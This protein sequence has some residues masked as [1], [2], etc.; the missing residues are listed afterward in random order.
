MWD[1]G[2]APTMVIEHGI[3]DPGHRYTGGI[4]RLA[5]VVNEPVRRWR[6]AGTDLLLAMAAGC[7]SRC[8]AWGCRRWPSAR[9]ALP[10][11]CT[12]TCRRRRMHAMLPAAPRLS[13]PLPLDQPG[14]VADRGDDARHAGAGARR[15]PR[16]RSAVPADA[17]VVSADPRGAGRHRAPVAGRSGRGARARPGRRRHAL[18]ALRITAFPVGLADLLK[19]VALMRIAMVSEHASPLAVLG[20]VDAGG[21]N[22]HVAALS[23][24]LAARGHDGH[25]LHPARR[26]RRRRD[27]CRSRPASTSM[28]VP[29]GPPGAA[30]Q[31]RPAAVHAAVRGDWLADAGADGPP[32]VVH[33][34]F[35]MSGLAA[36][37]RGAGARHPGRAD[38][39][40]ARHR[41]APPPG[42]PR[43]Q[44]RRR[45]ELE[46][47]IGGAS[48]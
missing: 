47:G 6:V 45:I 46:T 17:G 43:H 29:A 22:V 5:A 42:R 10:D 48:T 11:T 31:G 35:W 4:D 15:P 1:C 23:A 28:H 9:R 13:A 27:G 33:A 21:Q 41:Q 36:L 2:R 34:H 26:R 7:R 20:G 32:D 24:A 25:G 44:P 8:T 3:P 30:A 38:L 39:P 16:R 40:R 37:R 12:T 19:E 14:T 18:R